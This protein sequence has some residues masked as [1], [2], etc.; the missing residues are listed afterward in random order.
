MEESWVGFFIAPVLFALFF[1]GCHALPVSVMERGGIVVVSSF[2][3]IV[4]LTVVL[5]SL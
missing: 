3:M 5:L 1:V 4:I 2:I